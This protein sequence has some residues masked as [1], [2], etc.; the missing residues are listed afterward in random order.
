M[1]NFIS[2]STQI[3]SPWDRGGFHMDM[4]TEKLVRIFSLVQKQEK[5]QAILVAF[6]DCKYESV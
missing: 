1:E 4:S 5:M 6:S 2:Y 3:V